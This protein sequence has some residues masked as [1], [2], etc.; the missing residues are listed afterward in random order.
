MSSSCV[1]GKIDLQERT[2]EGQELPAISLPSTSTL[3]D[4]EIQALDQWENPTQPCPEMPFD[5]VIR[6]AGLEPEETTVH[7]DPIAR[8][9][10]G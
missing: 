6:S 3:P 8:I 5:L 4:F 7:F 2:A 10:G 9:K 1:E